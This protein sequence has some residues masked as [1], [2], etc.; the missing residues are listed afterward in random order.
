MENTTISQGKLRIAERESYGYLVSKRLIDIIGSLI[1][2]IALSPLFLIISIR[3]KLE[4][5]KGAV[6][7]GH[8]RVGE[9]GEMFKCWKFTSMIHNAEEIMKNFT[10]EQKKEFAE[11]FKLKDDPRI[12]KI[13]NL[14]R[15]TSLDEFPQ[16]W[17]ILKGEMTLVGP[18]P[19]VTAELEKYGK[20]EENLKSVK[21]GL[22]GMWQVNGRSD[23]TY[24]ERV[25]MDMQYISKRT[26]FLDVYLIFRTIVKV[27]KKEGAY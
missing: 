20:Y 10:T 19:I 17:N 4:D 24:E 25:M 16:L 22:T 13:G 7:F 5:P 6:F 23:T 11:N 1:G 15:K 18:R 12:T 9:N 14:L 27:I 8:K 3:I 2:L 26:L 21:P